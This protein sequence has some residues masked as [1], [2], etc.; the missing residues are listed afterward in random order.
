MHYQTVDDVAYRR[1]FR[2]TTL[3]TALA[4]ACVGLPAMAQDSS[5]P[6]RV[7]FR[8]GVFPGS[9]KI[10][11][12]RF[13]NGNVILPGSYR[14]DIQVNGRTIR[15]ETLTFDSVSSE[16]DSRLCVDPAMLE[17]FGVDLGKLPE[18]DPA[19]DAGENAGSVPAG[20]AN[21]CAAIEDLVPGASAR[22]DQGEQLLDVQIAQAYMSRR[23]VDLVPRDELDSGVTAGQLQYNAN[24]YDTR[25]K[26][27]RSRRAH[28]GIRAGINAGDWLLRHQGSFGWDNVGG[29]RYQPSSTYAQR[30]LDR[31][32]SQI[33]IGQLYT[34]GDLFGSVRLQGVE[35]ATDDRMLPQS[36]TGYAPVVR[37][38]AET[39]ALVKVLQRGAVLRE[40]TVAPGPFEIDDL[41]AIGFGGDLEVIIR[42]ADGRER[43]FTVPYSGNT[44]LLRPGY[45]RF[46]ASAG[47]ADPLESSYQPFVVQAQLQRGLN[48]TVTGFA[49]VLKSDHYTSAQIGAAV[50]TRVG[51]LALDVTQAKLELSRESLSGQSVQARFTKQ[52]PDLGTSFTVGAYRYST[53]GYVDINQALRLKAEDRDGDNTRRVDRFRSRLEANI[54]QSLGR[55]GG[56]LYFSAS[57]HDFWNRSGSALSYTAGYNNSWGKVGYSMSAQ[58]SLELSTGRSDTQYNVSFS[59]PLGASPR[60]PRLNTT[61]RQDRN[62]RLGTSV[63]INGTAGE[64]AELSY[65]ATAQ[66]GGGRQSSLSANAQY[67]TSMATVG[68]SMSRGSDYRTHSLDASGALV[69]HADGVT[70]APRL[71]DTVALIHAPGATG[72]RITGGDGARIDSRGF[73][74]QAGLNPYR[75]NTVEIDPR[76]LSHDV[77][78][79]TTTRVAAPRN[80]AVV[81]LTFPTD[82]GRSVL[83]GARQSD[84]SGLPFA[85]GVFDESG[86]AVGNVGQGSRLQVR[87]D[88]ESGVLTVRWGEEPEQQCQVS[89]QLPPRENTPQRAPDVINQATCYRAPWI[90]GS[91]PGLPRVSAA[92]APADP[93]ITQAGQRASLRS[94]P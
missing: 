69:A 70:L 51:S 52:M 40:L 73:A 60:A 46:A 29:S 48:N 66:D 36:A 24:V 55:S 28:V 3:A 89:Y 41:Y 43:T 33:V 18:A 72:A 57:R 82:T 19:G 31:L 37:G 42:E 91:Q 53:R 45:T 76:G 67:K 83:V 78:L 62:D 87:T 56:S 13:N 93:S 88:I 64:H 16:D 77:L 9:V 34:K 50:N 5:T 85:A 80:G 74:V 90:A 71:G 59:L 30:D 26:D 8:S 61:L 17:R 65:G 1:G 81:S 92:S 38:V 47:R 84:G 10:D 49:G 25:F 14:A 12:S 7:E 58:R 11:L 94:M 75:F 4:G 68:A 79:K 54:S 44:R 35:V 63:G 27:V 23:P 21:H 6:P 39:N 15:S 2:L 22:F 32:Q 20:P 86:N